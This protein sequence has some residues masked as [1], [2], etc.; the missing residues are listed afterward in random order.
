MKSVV[1]KTT[2]QPNAKGDDKS[3]KVYNVVTTLRVERFFSTLLEDKTNI[4][5]EAADMV[6]AQEFAYFFMTCGPNYVRSLHRAQEVTSI[7]SFKASDEVEAQKFAESLRLFIYGNHRQQYSGSIEQLD[8]F[9]NEFKRTDTNGKIHADDDIMKSLSIDILGFGLGLNSEGSET[10]V[11]TSLD[12]FNEVMKFAFDSM[13][14]SDFDIGM[15]SKIEV[16]PWTDNAAFL[17]YAKVHY[18]RILTPK[19]RGLIENARRVVGRDDF[20]CSSPSRIV[21]DFGKCCKQHEIVTLSEDYDELGKNVTKSSCE[22]QHYLSPVT[23]KENLAINAEFVALLGSVAQDKTN[24][25]STLGQCVNTLRA[26]PARFDYSFLQSTSKAPFDNAVEMMYTVKELKAAL[27]P[28]AD[29]GILSIIGDEND[30]YFEM[31]Y[32]PCLSALYGFRK[33]GTSQGTNPKH[34]MAEP[35]Y[36]LEECTRPSCLEADKAWDRLN[37]NGCVDGLLARE[38]AFSPIPVGDDLYC[39]REMNAENGEE[40]CKY[41]FIPHAN[42]VMQMDNCRASLPKGRDGKGKDIQLSMSYLM[43]YFCMPQLAVGQYADSKKMADVDDSWTICVSHSNSICFDLIVHVGILLHISLSHTH[44]YIYR[45]KRLTTLSLQ[46]FLQLILLNI[47][48][49]NQL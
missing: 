49:W 35:W 16:I 41:Q 11:S 1:K 5:V 40:N 14:K 48:L 24:S 25:L 18:N 22:P 9:S 21:D 19:P 43:D 10:L 26:F 8:E 27:D 17:Q 23:M 38:S 29:L 7:F 37:G 12:E 4:T 33:D 46:L 39:A 32:Q 42:V 45:C 31:F 30:E 44:I 2:T 36:N 3:P 34:F 15:I 47:H 20:V 6:R 13:T 28:A